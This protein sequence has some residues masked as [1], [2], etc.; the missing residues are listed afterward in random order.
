MS[1]KCQANQIYLSIYI[2][3]QICACQ[4]HITKGWLVPKSS[5]KAIKSTDT[6]APLPIS[7]YISFSFPPN[8]LILF[9]ACLTKPQ[10]PFA[11]M[12]LYQSTQP[13]APKKQHKHPHP[14]KHHVYACAH[15]PCGSGSLG[16][17]EHDGHHRPHAVL[18][19][20]EDEGAGG[21]E[22]L[23]RGGGGGCVVGCGAGWMM[24]EWRRKGEGWLRNGHETNPPTHAQCLH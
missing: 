7:C 21:V 9:Y 8:T 22:H 3:I 10:Q 19:L 1:P 17:R 18:R 16:E 14:P 24:D 6:R 23:V 5:N 15:P 2:I 4:S 13:P 12:T 11:S 20:G